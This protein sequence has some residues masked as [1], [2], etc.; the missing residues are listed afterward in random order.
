MD[1]DKVTAGI[2]RFDESGRCFCPIY[3]VWKIEAV[4]AVRMGLIFIGD[5]PEKDAVEGGV[6]GRHVAEP[7]MLTRGSPC[8][9][10]SKWAAIKIEQD[11]FDIHPARFKIVEQFVQAAEE[12]RIEA[13][14]IG[15]SRCA[16]PCPI[17]HIGYRARFAV[18]NGHAHEVEMLRAPGA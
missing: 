17:S 4:F 5:G 3:V 7:E 12:N 8:V 13:F 11:Q 9:C 14:Q 10:V 18:A 16:A 2:V 6:A 15:L 1:G